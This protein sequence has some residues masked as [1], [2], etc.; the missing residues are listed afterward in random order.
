MSPPAPRALALAFVALLLVPAAAGQVPTNPS[1][2]LQESGRPDLIPSN[3]TETVTDERYDTKICANVLNVGEGPTVTPFHVTLRVDG[4]DVGEARVD[5]TLQTG[6][7]TKAPLCWNLPLKAGG[8][9]F[10]VTVDA[11]DTV[12]EAREDNNAFERAFYVPPTPKLDYR[13]AS[14]TVTPRIGK[15]DTT[16]TFAA[17]V[18]NIGTADAPPTEVDIVDDNG[19]IARLPLKALKVGESATVATVTATNFRPVGSFIARAIVDPRSNVSERSELNNEAATSFE[20]LEHPAPD[21]A[22]HNVTLVGNLTERRG[23]RLEATVVNLGDRIAQNLVVRLMNS[24]NASLGNATR[25]AIP[26]GSSATLQFFFLLP[27]GNHTLRLALDPD[28][29]IVERNESNNLYELDLVIAPAPHAEAL[30]N[31]VIDRI[32]A[33]PSDPRPGEPV[34]LTAF[35][36]NVGDNASRPH[37]VN[38]TINGVFAGSIRVGSPLDPARLV[39]VTVSWGGG[40]QDV[41]F[42]RATVDASGEVR[43][44]DEGDNNHSMEL[45]VATPAPPPA[46]P[47][48]TQPSTPTPVVTPPTEETPNGSADEAAR[49]AI[50]ELSIGTR[51]VPGGVKGIVIASLRNPTLTPV[52]RMTVTFKV[53]GQPLK[54]VLVSGLAGAA[55]GSASTG[56]VD[57]PPGNHTVTAEVRIL[58]STNQPVSA[59]RSYDAAAGESNTPG[60]E[61]AALVL[62][63]AAVALGRRKR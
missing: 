1:Q 52:P 53:D 39:P 14:I 23:L 57:L 38:F 33:S 59:Q 48:P 40:P 29:K 35:V 7:G 61:A 46:T 22:F 42:V 49:V 37:S 21:L 19:L 43:E 56:K 8:H 41:Y 50:A 15:P 58:G 13:V 2:P 24:T 12:L 54:E 17:T 47:T 55:T 30:P 28:R 4:Q 34:A 44:L 62:A 6:Q 11:H 31:L 26:S 9:S 3:P 36:R 18:Q 16:Q 51:A 63:V 45:V 25:S 27:E 60:F 20:V 10:R 5:E 32:D